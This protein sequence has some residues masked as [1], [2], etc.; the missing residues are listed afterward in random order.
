MVRDTQDVEL[1]KLELLVPT[2]IIITKRTIPYLST[3]TKSLSMGFPSMRTFAVKVTFSSAFQE[4]T[5]KLN[6]EIAL[7]GLLS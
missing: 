3:F 7:L 4:E 2:A 1:R 6:R 5:S